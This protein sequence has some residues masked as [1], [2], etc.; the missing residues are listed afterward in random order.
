MAGSGGKKGV[1]SNTFDEQLCKKVKEQF[2]KDKGRGLTSAYEQAQTKLQQDVYE[3]IKG[4]EPS[5][6]DHGKRHISNVQQNVL[7]LLSDTGIITELTGIEMY[8]LG[9]FILF[10]DVGN[11]FGRENHRNKVAEVFDQIRG[12][13]KSLR[14]E[15]ALVVK[16]T[17]AHTGTAQD[18]SRDTLKEVDETDHLE[19]ESV[20]LRELAAI[21]RFADELAEGPQR[22][23]DFMQ[24]MELYD[25][26]SI[27]FH[28]YASITNIR[29]DRR[30]GRII[31]TYEVAIEVEGAD[32]NRRE[33]LS[34]FLEFVYKRI[35][36]LNQERQYA[37]Y[38]SKLLDPFKL[39]E[40]TFNFHCGQDILDTALSP[41]RLTDI[42]V[43]GEPSK[44]VA[45]ID[46]KYDIETLVADLLSKCPG[47]IK[48]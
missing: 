26:D 32:E 4:V 14:H 29:I 11:I 30:H 16:A 7:H 33:K 23:S 27:I 47:G 12:T 25:E 19:G 21:L 20:R 28:E 9:M 34:K 17:K 39:T 35:L 44:E 8:C 41:L 5:L 43:P 40:V 13:A 36:K 24:D 46:A 15:K 38:Y 45:E 37:R 10:H 2:G 31:L 48:I 42:V 6:S 1:S 18:G 3:N 22:T